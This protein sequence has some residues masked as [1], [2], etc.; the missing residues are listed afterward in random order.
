VAWDTAL[1][2]G[3]LIVLLLFAMLQ[4]PR[5]WARGLGYPTTAPG[6]WVWGN[7]LWKGYMRALPFAVAGGFVWFVIAL[8]ALLV[9]RAEPDEYGL[10]VPVW[11]A[12]LLFGAFAYW[13]LTMASIML[14]NWPKALV[15]PRSRHERGAIRAWR[16]ARR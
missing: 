11:Y 15:P 1:W 12:L 5:A 4:L 8:G 9:H 6:W 14:F 3:F 13:A 16:A 2:L 10:H 7:E